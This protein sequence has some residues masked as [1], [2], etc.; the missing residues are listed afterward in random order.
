MPPREEDQKELINDISIRDVE[1]MLERRYIDITIKLVRTS[2]LM[3]LQE[4]HHPSDLRFALHILCRAST[5][6]VQLE[7]P[8]EL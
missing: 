6:S 4:E 5:L 8:S 7:S 3:K 1:V 2:A